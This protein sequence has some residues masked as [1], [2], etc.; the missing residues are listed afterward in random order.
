MRRGGHPGLAR[1]A[2]AISGASYEEGYGR[3]AEKTGRELT[4]CLWST[5]ALMARVVGAPLHP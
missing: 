5:E 3:G 4:R 2:H 1:H